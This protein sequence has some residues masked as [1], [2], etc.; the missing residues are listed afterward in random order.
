ME[1]NRTKNIIDKKPF[2]Y[3]DITNYIKNKNQN[4]PKL[5]LQ[6]KIIYQKIIE[7]RTKQHTVAGEIQWKKQLPNINFE[8]ILKNTYKPLDNHSQKTYITDD[9]ITQQKQTCICT[10][11]QETMLK[12]RLLQTNGRQLTPI[13]TL[14]KNK[15]IWK[16]YQTIL[17]KLTGQHYNPQ[18]YLDIHLEGFKYK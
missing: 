18:Q 4:I 9:Y 1:N 13:Y 17:S 2:Y 3:N 14:P 7:E 6:T 12:L 15:K 8:K 10:K 5:K 16:H 11:A